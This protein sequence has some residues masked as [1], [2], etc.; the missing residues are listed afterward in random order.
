MTLAGFLFIIT[1]IIFIATFIFAF[2]GFTQIQ[3]EEANKIV[4]KSIETYSEISKLTGY[5]TSA[6]IH[7]EAN[8]IDVF[9]H[10]RRGSIGSSLIA[11]AFLNFTGVFLIAPWAFTIYLYEQ[12]DAYGWGILFMIM[13]YFTLVRIAVDL[14]KRNRERVQ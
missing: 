1:A 2:L 14:F 7:Y 6:N 3:Q 9:H 8:I 13:S 11:V 4:D 5:K 10:A 12:H